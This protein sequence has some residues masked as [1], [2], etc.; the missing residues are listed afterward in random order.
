MI[1]VNSFQIDPHALEQVPE[2]ISVEN[3]LLPL[4]YDSRRLHIAIPNLGGAIPQLLEKLQF[5]LNRDISYELAEIDDI[6]EARALA[7]RM[8]S[9]RVERCGFEFQVRC[10]KLWTELSETETPDQRHCSTCNQRVHLSRSESEVR[11]HARLGHCVA[12]LADEYEVETFDSMGLIE[13]PEDRLD[14]S[15]E[16][17]KER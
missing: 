11:E 3:H 16:G 6:D 9:S 15:P 2:S 5:I 12:I 1:L 4:K 13:F 17:L 7:W 10:S 8:L 14:E